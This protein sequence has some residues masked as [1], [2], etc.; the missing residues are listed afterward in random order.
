MESEFFKKLFPDCILSRKQNEKF[1]FATTQKGYRFAT[2]IGGTLTGEG[3]DILIIDDPHNPQNISSEL[4]RNKTLDWY[5]NTFISRLNDK[6]NGAII[7]VMQ[8]LHPEDLCGFLLEKNKN[9]WFHLNLP[10]IAEKD[11]EI[12]IGKFKKFRKKG[13]ILFPEREGIK[14]IEQI[15]YD[16]G[17]YTF[18]AQYQQKPSIVESCMLKKEWIKTYKE[19]LNYENIFLSFDTAI[20]TGINNDPTVCTVWGI[21]EKNYYLLDVFREWLEYPKLKKETIKLIE[22][23]KPFATLIEDK[24]SGQSLIQDLKLETN[25]SIIP[26]KVIKDKITRFASITPFFESEKI[27]LPCEADWIVDFKNELFSFPNSLHDDQVDSTSQF[28]NWIKNNETRLKKN[29]SIRLV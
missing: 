24:A 9:N 22:K 17:L 18:N 13:E 2:S 16:M 7:I 28:L 10:A 26:I 3:G 8:R 20:K 27:F 29:Y 6:K 21:Y 12:V 19:Q 11:E 4:I 25:Y 15:K 14:E 1:K 23:W 5:N